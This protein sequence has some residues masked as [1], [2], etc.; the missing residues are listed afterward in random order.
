MELK[1]CVEHGYSGSNLG[2]IYCTKCGKELI[3]YPSCFKCGIQL[4]PD[5]DFCPKCGEKRPDNRDRGK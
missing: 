2:Y 4:L 3:P 5:Q 1:Y